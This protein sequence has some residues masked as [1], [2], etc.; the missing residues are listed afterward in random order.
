MTTTYDQSTV[1]YDQSTLTYQGLPAQFDGVAFAVEMAFG[2]NPLD[3]DPSWESVTP[4]VRGFSTDR[5]RTSE[6]V[7]YSPGTASILLDNRTRRFDPEYTSG[8]YYGDLVPMVPVRVQATYDSVT[9]TLYRGFVQG[10]PTAYNLSNTDAVSNI[11]CIDA[12]RLLAQL[13]TPVTLYE[14]AVLDTDPNHYWPLTDATSG[15]Q[16]DLANNYGLEVF[17]YATANPTLYR[18]DMPAGD[19]TLMGAQVGTNGTALASL[20]TYSGP[21][22]SVSFIVDATLKNNDSGVIGGRALFTNATNDGIS[23][24]FYDSG[25]SLEYSNVTDNRYFPDTLVSATFTRDRANMVTVT[26]STSTI[27]VYV[28]GS[29]VYSNSLSTGTTTLIALLKSRVYLQARG[30]L[31]QVAIWDTELSAATV[32]DLYAKADG[33]PDET[34]GARL[35]RVLDSVG[36]PSAWRDI[37]NGTLTVGPYWT[38]GSST[39]EVARQ[40]AAAESGEV[41]VNREGNVTFYDQTATAVANIDGL[42]DDEGTDLPYTDIAVDAYTV[43]DIANTVIANYQYGTI[44]VTDD[45]SVTAY[46]TN[47]R[48]LDMRV[49]F[50]PVTVRAA[51]QTILDRAAQPRTRINKLGVA[52]RRDPANI[53]PVIAPLDLGDDV[54][55]SLTPTGVGDPL[56]RAVSVQGLS[57]TV[58][59]DSWD[60]TMYLAPG[61]IATN[62]PL[63]ILDDAV[64]GQLDNNKLG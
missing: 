58:T 26:A 51:A 36:W 14:Q 31:G 11:R 50:D 28:N 12:S 55:V 64:Y 62:G 52:V 21:L 18:S 24:S 23:L 7:D 38:G 22:R 5:G 60:V 3:D 32:A 19:P 16:Y 46:G 15:V 29:L 2:Y 53:V 49:A 57:H 63:M 1:T 56:W 48:G 44:T 8:P 20:D 41:F 35:G 27:K 45:A 13:E 54:V 17:I 43:D 40:L 37:D 59:P 61:P 25:I 42:F 9:Y 30:T 39:I 4:Y 6:F 33:Y 10:W 47:S 34:T